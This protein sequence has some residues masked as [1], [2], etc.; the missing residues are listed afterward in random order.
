MKEYIKSI[1]KA[2]S[3][4]NFGCS[5]NGAEET[6]YY[7]NGESQTFRKTKAGWRIVRKKKRNK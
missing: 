7:E 6:H 5:I 3:I 1:K 2:C 4:V